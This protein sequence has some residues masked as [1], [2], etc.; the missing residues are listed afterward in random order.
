MGGD[1]I[2]ISRGNCDGGI[3]GRGVFGRSDCHHVQY[4]VQKSSALRGCPVFQT[5]LIYFQ[6]GE[7]IHRVRIMHIVLGFVFGRVGFMVCLSIVIS[8]CC[9]AI[10][11]AFCTCVPLLRQCVYVYLEFTLPVSTSRLRLLSGLM[12]FPHQLPSTSRLTLHSEL[13]LIYIIIISCR[14]CKA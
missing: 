9:L 12:Q 4:P 5:V 7:A 14:L 1:C 8:T 2:C 10:S 11:L 13:Y 3:W 6:G